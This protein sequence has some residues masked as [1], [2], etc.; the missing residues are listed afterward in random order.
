MYLQVTNQI[1]AL[2]GDTASVILMITDGRINDFQFASESVS[3]CECLMS[4][5]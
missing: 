3:L 1:M 2:G 4:I 5:T